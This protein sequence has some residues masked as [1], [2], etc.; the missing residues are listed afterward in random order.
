MDGCDR[1]DGGVG[2]GWMEWEDIWW[3]DGDWLQKLDGWNK[4]KINGKSKKQLYVIV[5][6]W[7]WVYIKYIL[8]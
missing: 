4:D 5:I 6:F 8:F 3:L 2:G 7:F 1:M